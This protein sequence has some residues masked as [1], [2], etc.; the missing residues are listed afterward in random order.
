MKRVYAVSK[1]GK[2]YEQY[3]RELYPERAEEIFHKAE[4]Y[5][6]GLVENDM[7]DLGE[8]MM[9]ANMLD[10][11][12]IVSFYEASDHKLDGDSLLPIKHRARD[13]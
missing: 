9:A 2:P 4:E 7:P 13:K 12:T 5:Y 10:W 11:F 3:C 8:N 1:Y 6:K